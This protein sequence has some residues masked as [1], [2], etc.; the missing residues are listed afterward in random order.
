MGVGA[1]SVVPSSFA[2][3]PNNATTT[4]GQR[5][6]LGAVGEED[7][8]QVNAEESAENGNA[9]GDG[10][11][12]DSGEATAPNA[13]VAEET[14]RKK[15]ARKPL[16]KPDSTQ[17]EAHNRRGH[18]PF[19]PW[20]AHCRAA[21]ATMHPHQSKQ[22]DEETEGDRPPMLVMDYMYMSRAKEV[23]K[24]FIIAARE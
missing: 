22:P 12:V 15:A 1:A 18:V 21:R 23:D 5:H 20:C 2:V 24:R 7:D 16:E 9:E 11:G 3:R 6:I 13:S 17:I 19:A 14:T 4:S 8:L 10:C